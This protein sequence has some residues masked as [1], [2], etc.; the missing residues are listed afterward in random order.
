MARKGMLQKSH[1]LTTFVR[2]S[3]TVKMKE[4]G[5]GKVCMRLWNNCFTEAVPWDV[6][7]QLSTTGALQF[8]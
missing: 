3:L 1:S 4:L 7:K 8:I 5:D 6:M 2:A